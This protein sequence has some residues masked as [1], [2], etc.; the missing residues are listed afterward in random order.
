[1][2]SSSGFE[3]AIHLLSGDQAYWLMLPTGDSTTMVTALVSTSTKCR[4]CL[5]SDQA[6][7]LLSG[8]QT[9]SNL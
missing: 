5:R 1:M 6:I 3:K 8:D 7:F 2:P 9:A 4:R